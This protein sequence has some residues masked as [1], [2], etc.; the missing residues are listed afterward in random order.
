[1][2]LRAAWARMRRCR[3]CFMPVYRLGA[4]AS[5]PKGGADW[6][7]LDNCVVLLAGGRWLLDGTGLLDFIR[8]PSSLSARPILTMSASRSSL[9]AVARRMPC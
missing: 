5:S 2:V 6:L 1:M 3:R 8:R 7:G 9:A 4:S